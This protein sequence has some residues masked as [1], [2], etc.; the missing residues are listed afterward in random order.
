MAPEHERAAHAA[1]KALLEAADANAELKAALVQLATTPSEGEAGLRR[2]LARVGDLGAAPADLVT[3][4]SGGHVEK[5]VNIARANTIV[6]A[7]RAPPASLFGL[8]RDVAEFTG[9]DRQVKELVDLLGEA[10][11]ERTAVVVSALAGKPG[12]GKS[13]LAIHVAHRLR[14]RYPDAQLY[15]NLRG[16]EPERLSPWNVL[17]GF[18]ESLG[19]AGDEIPE[20]LDQRANVF[21]ARL[22]DRRALVLLD[23][24]HDEVQVRPLLPGSASC[25]VLITSRSPLGA[26]DGAS[27]RT[28]DVMGHD[29]AVEL[30]SKL[31]GSGRVR[32]E[33]EH[34]AEIA[35][36][37]GHLPLALRIAGGLLATRPSWT[38]AKLARRLRDER[39]RLDELRL[40]DLEVRGSFALSYAALDDEAARVFR[41]LAVL[42]GPD[43][44]TGVVTALDDGAAE[45]V[46]GVL[47][48]LA[49]A[50]LLE[51][52][53]EDRYRFHDLIALFARERAGIEDP[54][55]ARRL[56]ADRARGWYLAEAQSAQGLLDLEPSEPRAADADSEG[57]RERALQWLASERVNLVAAIEQAHAQHDWETAV[58]LANSLTGFLSL[59][60][61]WDDWSHTSELGLDAARRSGARDDEMH[62]LGSL[63][64]V[65][66]RRGRQDDAIDSYR[67]SL[68]I[69]RERGDRYGEGMA[70]TNLGLV[71]HDRGLWDEAIDCY[72]Q[73]L[74]IC[75]ALG[76]RHGEANALGNLAMVYSSQGRWE[77]AVRCH[78]QCLATM[79]E[80]GDRGRAAQ[81]LNN[82]ANILA[83]QGD[84]DRALGYYEE[85]LRIIREEGDPYNEAKMLGNLALIYSD[86]ERTDEA[87]AA[88]QRSLEIHRDL[89]NLHGEAAALNNLGVF[90]VGQGRYE[91]AVDYHGI[92]LRAMRELGDRHGEAVVLMSLGNVR[93]HQEL[94]AEAVECYERSVEIMHEI[95]DSNGEAT[96]LANLGGTYAQQGLWIGASDAYER[97]LDLLRG[98]EDRAAEAGAHGSIG[99]VYA[100]QG[101]WVEAAGAFEECVRLMR[102]LHDRGGEARALGDLGGAY[103]Q[104]D[105]WDDAGSC[106]EQALVIARELGDEDLE[107][108]ALD[109]LAEVRMN[110]ERW[111]VAVQLFT[112]GLEIAR[113]S[114]DRVSEGVGL[115]NVGLA[116]R[117]NG[118]DAGAARC[119]KRALE[120]LTELGAPQAESVRALVDATVGAS[121]TSARPDPHPAADPSGASAHNRQYI[122]DLA[123]WKAL[124]WL[125]RRLAKRP[126][127]PTGI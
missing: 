63:G 90:Y 85:A 25:A 46:E 26:L 82:L 7:E 8:P 115:A 41:R 38:L 117:A 106:H 99:R 66:S 55:E 123:R 42:S 102:A 113:R 65:Y 59:R 58:E 31:A 20:D 79:R 34:A 98:T 51:E 60:A 40:G 100:E 127:R 3:Y 33:P 6:V 61:Y 10:D 68:A 14:A 22:A 56:A 80:L 89:G 94:W 101:R 84:T 110:Q 9:R 111:E 13:A 109:N 103:G 122:E 44:G 27:L 81:T 49:H 1:W 32:R 19:V 15:V 120:I 95:G 17:A 16:P 21:R 64:V 92:S 108:Q 2:W 18:L 53:I 5:L 67:G 36:L 114:G 37:C 112:L 30:L 118:D 116:M 24:A 91:E 4:V 62:L 77:K 87:F 52:P 12:V 121:T 107:E 23:N 105:R 35:R 96:S 50:Q 47:D 126:Q 104:Q 48:R 69:A 11:G 39:R 72:K 124:P 45:R 119:I 28:L 78:L 29:A 57:A 93:A 88:L 43:F 71:L 83:D 125:K 86:R 70:L 76:N 73:A 74:P 54:P 97:A 75:R